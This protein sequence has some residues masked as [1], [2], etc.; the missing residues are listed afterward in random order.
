MLMLILD[1]VPLQ[2]P[3]EGWSASSSLWLHHF[4]CIFI[5]VWT[6]L[7]EGLD[8]P[9]AVHIHHGLA[10]FALFLNALVVAPLG[11]RVKQVLKGF[12]DLSNFV[13]LQTT[14]LIVNPAYNVAFLSL[15]GGF[16]LAFVLL[17]LGIKI[18]FKFLIAV[19]QPDDDT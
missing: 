1:A 3:G 6:V 11:T 2:D 7:L 18:G 8:V 16:Q 9:R 17:L 5:T 14:I 15:E 10:T 19:L 13:D 4:V 12:L